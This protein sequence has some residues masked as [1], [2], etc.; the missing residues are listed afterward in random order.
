VT[1]GIGLK[2]NMDSLAERGLDPLQI[3][4]DAAHG[5]GMEFI[6]SLRAPAYLGL[7]KAF[8]ASQSTMGIM[9]E[10]A[11][12]DAQLAILTELATDYDT[13]GVE[14]DLSCGP[15]GASPALKPSDA[16]EYGPVLTQWVGAVASVVHNRPAGRGLVGVR[17][18]P[19]AEMNAAFGFDVEAWIT[20]GYV[21]Y[22][23]PMLCASLLPTPLQSL[24]TLSLLIIMCAQISTSCWTHASTSAG[25]S[26]P[27]LRQT[28]MSTGCFSR[29]SLQMAVALWN[30]QLPRICTPRRSTSLRPQPPSTPKAATACVRCT[31]LCQSMWTGPL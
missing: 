11:V 2:S 31:S 26:P 20:A 9:A 5:H 4:I 18:F 17:V 15:G 12:R 6:A 7:D 10:A 28:P 13:D 22:I 24:S 21:D 25:P 14:I 30:G 8:S 19:T 1:L 23:V 29:T 27:L 16:A 3:L